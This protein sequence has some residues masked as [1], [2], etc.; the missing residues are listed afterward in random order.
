MISTEKG[1][2]KPRSRV[3]A[4]VFQERRNEILGRIDSDTAFLSV[5]SLMKLNNPNLNP[6]ALIKRYQY[7]L[8]TSSSRQNTESQTEV[9]SF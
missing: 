8:Y 2:A 3:T 5:V 4:H 9:I 6:E 7:D 1:R